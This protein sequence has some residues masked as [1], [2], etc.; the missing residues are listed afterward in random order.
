MRTTQARPKRIKP[1]TTKDLPEEVT[2]DTRR[3]SAGWWIA[4]LVLLG[5]AVAGGWWLT[6]ALGDEETPVDTEALDFTAVQRTDL[7]VTESLDGT[8]GHPAGDPVLARISTQNTAGDDDVT[9]RLIGTLTAVPETG[10]TLS[11]GDVLWE[12]NDQPVVLL[13]GDI[14]AYRTL[15]RNVDDGID[16]LQLETA[17]AAMG[18]DPDVTVTID[19]DF[20]SNTESMVERWQED[21]GAVEDGVVHLGELVFATGNIQVAAVP[22]SVGDQV[23]DGDIVISTSAGAGSGTLTAIAQ[24]GVTLTQGDELFRVDDEPVVLLFGSTPAY[25]SMSLGITDGSDV[26]QLETA[27]SALGYDPAGTVPIDESFTSE[28]TAMIER[29]QADIG[30]NV[31][32]TVD[33]GEVVFLKESIRVASALKT[34][35]D[36]V[37]DAEAVLA[38]ST[39]DTFVTIELDTDDQGLVA[40]GDAVT[41]VLPG[42]D[43]AAATVTGVGTVAVQVQGG[44]NY[45]EITVTL[46][47]PAAGAGVDEAP[48]E[49]EIVDESA[50]NVLAVPVT[51]LLALAEGGYAVQVDDGAGGTFLVAVDPG[52]FADGLVEITA[53]GLNAG[54]MVV[55]P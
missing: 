23:H 49:I 1:I 32:G 8:L 13:N 28:T 11:Q 14:P 7:V 46:D 30:A 44:P 27:L 55:V 2:L 53:D 24:E 45:F 36:P 39:S 29:W 48:V 21:T 41:V 52:L 6:G 43:T 16:V 5:V 37:H 50:N 31:D 3:R 33:F 20:T 4:G 12:V 22:K 15:Q 54:D 40:E 26:A 51:A 42:G 34:P 25:R 35:G 17:L 18:Y 9:T 47:D 38:T 19:E 10:V